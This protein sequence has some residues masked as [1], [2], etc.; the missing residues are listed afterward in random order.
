M[1]AMRHQYIPRRGPGARRL[2]VAAT[3]TAV[4]SVATPSA[5]EIMISVQDGK[6]LRPGEGPETR[7]PD[8][9]ALIEVGAGAPRVISTLP[10]AASLIGPPTSV[11]VT[12]D[13]ALALVTAAQ[14][15]DPADGETIVQGR[16]LT[17]V[18]IVSPTAPR[19]IRT[20][21]AGP[22]A[23]GVTI[24]AQGTLALVAST[25]DDVVSIYAIRQGDVTPVGR[26]LMPY[27]SRPTDVVFT[28]DGLGVLVVLQTSGR[29]ARFHVHGDRLVKA[30]A[31]IPL[32]LQPTGVAVS[33][34]G[35]FAFVTNAGGRRPAPGAPAAS[36]GGAI[37]VVDLQTNEVVETI[38]AGVG[39]EHIALSPDGRFLQVT[40]VNGSSAPPGSAAHNESGRLKIFAVDEGRLSPVAEAETGQ[41]CQGSAWTEDGRG[42]L[43]QCALKKQ[44]EFY[45]FADGRLQRDEAA[46]LTLNARPAAI[47]GS[48][49]R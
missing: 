6:V 28:P 1:A 9:L 24:N 26:A 19:L 35:R 33:R 21:S 2:S 47:V 22:G 5:G 37:S 48:T 7:T 41:W 44:I 18:D 4:L 23:T 39:L 16:S 15:L 43:L 32:G 10:A 8:V 34:D 14:Q 20:L 17:V 30:G 27:Q 40:L 31:D 46:T 38:D 13:R 49:N 36:A 3:V 12:P 45:R 25:G 11:A 42:L 29:L